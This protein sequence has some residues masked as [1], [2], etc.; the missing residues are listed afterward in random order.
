[1]PK[2]CLSLEK[3]ALIM[4]MALNNATLGIRSRPTS[5][6]R[7]ILGVED[8]VAEAAGLLKVTRWPAHLTCSKWAGELRESPRTTISADLHETVLVSKADQV[9]PNRCTKAL[10]KHW[11]N[12]SFFLIFTSLKALNFNLFLSLKIINLN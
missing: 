5:S 12:L 6:S 10:L 9:S 2:M 3:R 1:M 7:R 11:V 4:A 8:A